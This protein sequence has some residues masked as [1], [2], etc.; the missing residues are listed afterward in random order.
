[1]LNLGGWTRRNSRMKFA[2]PDAP[3]VRPYLY[4]S[5][6]VSVGARR[7]ILL[8]SRTRQTRKLR[9]DPRSDA[10]TVGYS[11]RLARA[12]IIVTS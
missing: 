5:F 9:G 3:A 2:K 11:V 12:G 8:A 10:R 4:S 7:A 1:M 6:R